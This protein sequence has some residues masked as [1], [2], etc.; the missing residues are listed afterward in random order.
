MFSVKPNR[1]A[2]SKQEINVL[3][4]ETK[5][6][7]IGLI[8]RLGY[9]TGMRLGEIS[10][11]TWDLVR[12]NDIPHIHLPKE[13]SKNGKARDIPLGK[14]SL[15]S[16]NCRKYS[17]RKS[18]SIQRFMSNVLWRKPMLYRKNADGGNT[19]YVV[20]KTCFGKP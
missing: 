11:L 10:G 13:K 7:K 20:S 19:R 12:L 4:Q 3:L 2:F 6:T 15:S 17:K 5:G 16:E 8:I 9:Y 1:R 18:K 14:H